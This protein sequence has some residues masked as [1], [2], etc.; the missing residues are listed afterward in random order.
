M[1]HTSPETTTSSEVSRNP[2]PQ[3]GREH[4]VINMPFNAI[5]D[6]RLYEGEGIS[7]VG[8]SVRGLVSPQLEGELRLVTLV[9]PFSGFNVAIPLDAAIETASS[10]GAMSLRFTNPSGPHLPQLRHLLN[11]YISGDIA[12]VKSVLAVSPADKPAAK[13]GSRPGV[14]LGRVLS[15]LLKG[16]LITA[17]SAAM[18]GFV[19]VKTYERLAVVYP[20]GISLVGRQNV[21]LRAV[22]S[23]QVEFVNQQAGQGD[24]AYSIRSVSGDSTSV[25]MPC[26]CVPLP[27]VLET[28]ATVLAGDVVMA[29]APRDAALQVPVRL[30]MDGYRALQDGAA[31]DITLPS[32]QTIA[33]T[34]DASSVRVSADNPDVL[35]ASLLPQEPIDTTLIGQPVDISIHRTELGKAWDLIRNF[36]QREE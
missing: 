22:T 36:T 7:L 24:I 29:V 21:E 35:L 19:G 34:L 5:V 3:L 4:P 1:Q 18:F 11:S 15:S 2:V 12:D 23:G 25:S 32:G 27:G 31:A 28:G 13:G 33:A 16:L 8:A 20:E 6:G 17:A 30:T 26:D 10:S 9:F 14:A